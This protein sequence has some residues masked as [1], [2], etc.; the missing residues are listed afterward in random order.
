MSALP[1]Q[2]EI[3]GTIGKLKSGKAGGD[4]GILPEMVKAASCQEGFFHLL[5]DL[6][7]AVWCECRVSKE[8]LDKCQFEV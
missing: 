2:E 7:Y 5:M 8:W 6:V 1:S 4:S 3:W